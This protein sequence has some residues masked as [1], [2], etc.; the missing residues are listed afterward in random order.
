MSLL[1]EVLSCLM[2]SGIALNWIASVAGQ[3]ATL[4]RATGQQLLPAS[5]YFIEINVQ[6]AA[7]NPSQ[8]RIVFVTDI[9]GED[10]RFIRR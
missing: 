9:K 7:G 4:A 5:T 10:P 3:T 1:Q 6:D 8:I 2:V